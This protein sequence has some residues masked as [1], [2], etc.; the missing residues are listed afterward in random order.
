MTELPIPLAAECWTLEISEQ[1]PSEF[2][3]VSYTVG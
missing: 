3:A 2:L 1:F